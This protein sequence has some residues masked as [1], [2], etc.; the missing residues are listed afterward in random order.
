M[1]RQGLRWPKTEV[2]RDRG[3]HGQRWQRW[4][5]TEMAEVTGRCTCIST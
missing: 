4:P 1:K 2:A 3:D 5:E